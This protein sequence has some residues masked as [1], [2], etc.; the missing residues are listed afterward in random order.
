MLQSIGWFM[1]FNTNFNNISVISWQSVLLVK[2]TGENHRPVCRKSL[3]N[4]IIKYSIGRVL[5]VWVGFELNVS[6]ES[7]WLHS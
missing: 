4:F 7:L 2:E 5:L 6:G 1:V 3:T